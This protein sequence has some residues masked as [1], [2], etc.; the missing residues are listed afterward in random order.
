MVDHDYVEARLGELRA[1]LLARQRLCELRLGR[2]RAA[3]R[4]ARERGEMEGLRL[5]YRWL[6]S[7]MFDIRK[8]VD[9]STPAI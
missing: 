9:G 2:A 7:A 8:R 4:R 5:S 1:Q 3:A 6:D